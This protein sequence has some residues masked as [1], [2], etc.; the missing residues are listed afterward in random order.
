[1]P[2]YFQNHNKDLVLAIVRSY[3]P[4]FKFDGAEIKMHFQQCNITVAKTEDLVQSLKNCNTNGN[5]EKY[6]AWPSTFVHVLHPAFISTCIM[7]MHY[8]LIVHFVIFVVD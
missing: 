4:K 1:M 5:A 7:S 6:I 8:V 2:V 3:D